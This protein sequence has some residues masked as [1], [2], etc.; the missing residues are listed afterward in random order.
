MVF[1]LDKYFVVFAAVNYA[2]DHDFCGL[3]SFIGNNL[4]KQYY[5]L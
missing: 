4:T 1:D 2:Q 5:L 3:W